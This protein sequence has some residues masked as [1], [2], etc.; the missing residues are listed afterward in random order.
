MH[1][2]IAM[3]A[4]IYSGEHYSNKMEDLDIFVISDEKENHYQ[5]LAD[6]YNKDMEPGEFRMSDDEARDNYS[7]IASGFDLLMD[8]GH[9]FREVITL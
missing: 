4:Y 9:V 7:V 8:Q 6:H 5:L 2:H 3:T 1:Q